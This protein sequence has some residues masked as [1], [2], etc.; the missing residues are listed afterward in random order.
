M[1]SRGI[2]P[3]KR[4]FRTLP[5]VMAVV[6]G[7]YAVPG[8]AQDSSQAE[9]LDQTQPQAPQEAPA[10]GE[11]EATELDTV[12]VTG[13]LLR[14]KE[15]ESTSPVQVIT[16]DTNVALGQVNA[17]EFLQKS[18]VAA[19]ETQITNQ[20][21]GFVVEGG[22]GVQTLSLR[23]LGA[24]RT[25]VL[26]DGQRPGPAGTRGQVGAFDLNVM[27]SSILQRVEI[28]K[29]GA[30]SIYGSDAVAGVVNMITRKSVDRPELTFS[31]R[32][33]VESGG[34]VFTISGATGWEFDNGTIVAAGEWYKQEALDV[35]DRDFF[36]CPEDLAYDSETGERIDREDRS[37]LAGTRLAGCNNLYANTYIDYFTGARY[38][39]SPDGSGVY[40]PRN[41]PTYAGGGQAYY[42][43]VLNYDFFG[44]SDVINAQDRMSLFAASDFS[45]DK[46]NWRTQLL[47]NKRKTESRGFRQFFPVVGDGYYADR[48]YPTPVESGVAQPIM[49]FRSD[50]DIEVDYLYGATRF[51]GLIGGTETWA[52]EANATHSRS[53]GDYSNL[54]IVASR[55]GDLT[56]ENFDGNAP[57][58]NYFDPG[59]L[60]GTRMDELVDILGE[61]HTGNTVY[62]QTTVNAVATGELFSLPAGPVSAAVGLEHR[63]YS[64]HDQPSDLSLSGNI[65]GST[66]AGV[67]KGKDK[68]SEAFGEI[69][70]PILAGVPAFESLTFNA[71]GR[72]F[73]YDSVEGS[74][75]VWKLGLNWQI[76]PAVKLRATRGTSFRAPGLYELYLGDQTGF[77][78][79][80]Q[81][82]PCILWGESTNDFLRANCAAAGIPATYNGLG[83]SS[84][85]I[86]SG[87][88]AGQLTPETSKAFTTG[89]VFTPAFA[90]L[91]IAVDYFDYEVRN[92]I[93]LLD[94]FDI[95]FGCYGAPVYPN[96]FC[97]LF[98]RNPANAPAAANQI[99]EVRNQYVNI[100]RQQVK[101][102]DV[103]LNYDR[104][105]SFGKFELESQVTYTKEDISQLFSS[106]EE[107]GFTSSNFVGAIGR[108]KVVGNLNASLER[109][110]WTYVWGMQYVGGT[111]NIDIDPEYTYQGRPAWRDIKADSR[112]YHTLAAHYELDD[113]SLLMGVQNVFNAKPP[114]V[115]SGAATRYGNVPAFA[116][117]Y[118]YLGRTPYVRLRLKF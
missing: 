77:L 44:S 70:V 105:F 118:D 27:P 81:I 88:G 59:F 114:V 99:T 32:T 102:Y 38:I 45:F 15:Y 7:L 2:N 23:G 87:G 12:T 75:K 48:A 95:L 28:V 109:N 63:R 60:S 79:Q 55:T 96:A 64:I 47:Y 85:T 20:F 4:S 18:S 115:S 50:N 33:P 29:D 13:S 71:S 41:N 3:G 68:V 91:S 76:V 100:N 21:G 43:D 72:V 19:G 16:A 65:W 92:Q 25:L 10:A 8:L 42:E 107:S 74:D 80:T 108:P 61:W 35:G 67:T 113:W 66:L 73:E 82:D 117:Q 51:D 112:L 90:N 36:E 110:D 93:G 84:A 54:A 39:P 40:R 22:T 30:S 104:E 69:E 103:L 56:N 5:L 34:E 52:W 58:V 94:S 57:P 101:G 106:A 53:D 83:G 78:A 116:T 98:E 14:R 46:F 111:E 49:P 11:V 37:I 6:A 1:S 31:M 9:A 26:L 89:I 24:N 17:A 62:K 97:D 86:Y